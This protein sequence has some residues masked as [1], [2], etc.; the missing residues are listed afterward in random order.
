MRV[1]RIIPLLCAVSLT[2]QACGVKDYKV[3]GDTVLVDRAGVSVRLQVVSPEIIRVNAV[4]AGAKFT[5]R[6]SLVV[7]PQEGKTSFDVTSEG[8]SV[9]VRTGELTAYLA[10]D[11]SLGFLD[12]EGNLLAGDGKMSFSVAEVEGKKG[13]SVLTR[14]PSGSG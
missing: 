13:Y 12:S 4:P 8:G 5:D 11:G 14:F 6:K 3:K 2:F 1:R 10:A 9:Y 7:V